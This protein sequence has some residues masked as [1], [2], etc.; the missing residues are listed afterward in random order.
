MDKRAL[1]FSLSLF[2]SFFCIQT[3]FD[4]QRNSKK[5]ETIAFAE[6]IQEK[7]KQ[8]SALLKIEDLPIVSL[9]KDPLAQEKIGSAI[10]CQNLFLTLSQEKNLPSPLYTKSSSHQIVALEPISSA[11]DAN[12][13]VFYRAQGS[14]QS[15]IQIPSLEENLDLQLLS[16]YPELQLAHNTSLEHAAI[17]LIKNNHDY[18]PVGIFDPATKK[19]KALSEFQKL[20]TIV[21]NDPQIAPPEINTDEEFYVLENEYQQ[22]VFSTKGGALA[23]INL[24][25]KT[26]ENPHNIIKEIDFDREIIKGSPENAYFPLRPYYR[27][28][29]NGQTELSQDRMFGGYYPLLRRPIVSQGQ[30][31]SFPS[32]YYALAIVGDD[33]AIANLNYKVTRFEKNLIQF[34]ARN[35]N[36]RIIKTFS[37][38]EERR[39]PYCFDLSIEMTGDQNHLWLSSGVPDVE[40]LADSYAPLLR[41][42]FTKNGSLDVDTIDLPKKDIA[43]YPETRPNWI[44]NC[45]GFLGLIQQPIT[46]LN[47][48]YR[49]AQVDGSTLPTRLTLIDSAYQLYPAS[50]YPGYITALPLSGSDLQF[51]IFAGPYDESLL[52]Q[53]DELYDDPIHHYNPEFA[54]AQKIQGWFSFIS[55]PFA[56]FLSL[57]MSLFYTITRSW[58]ASI[59]LLTIALRAMMYP[60]NNWHI[61]STVKMQELG[62]KIKALQERY[63][64]D[65]KRAQLE[66]MN[67]YRSSGVNPFTGCIPM[68][69][70]IPF[71]MGMFYLL[72]SSFSLRGAPFILGWIDDLA[73]PDI[74]FSWGAPLWIIGNELHL[75]PILNGL[76]MYLQQKMTAQAPKD[77]KNLSDAEKQQK[78]MA[79]IFPIVITFMFYSFPSGL[80]LYFLFS[81]ILGVA[82]QKWMTLKM[83]PQGT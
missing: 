22:L 50:K 24:P 28:S 36:R 12:E 74:L 68:L 59:I 20:H 11:A 2:I 17:A 6:P 3:W 9:F 65:P 82:Q 58:A 63:K 10:L 27:I 72:K 23:E 47:S 32:Q 18:V 19:I 79:M 38:P 14:L 81:T 15:K 13:P 75:L 39:G 40:I 16:V 73:A 66:T 52:K 31:S 46:T 54:S 8:E 35:S 41:F 56:R 77:E 5:T 7:R 45:N 70:Q 67:L 71:L 1:F 26:K 49:V 83:K 42:Q 29:E 37:I 34:E 53:I 55:E 21:Y 61:K 76:A 30:L 48:G 25:Q 64:N 80:N 43:S 57:L 69:L 78:M 51:R 44:S 60:L 4:Y 62:P 33:P